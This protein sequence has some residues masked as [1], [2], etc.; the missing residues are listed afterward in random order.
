[1]SL[2][3]PI[4]STI[5][6]GSG[7][8]RSNSQIAFFDFGTTDLSTEVFSDQAL[9]V[10]ITNPVALTS[11]GNQPSIHLA[12]QFYVVQLQD[13]GGTALQQI[14]KYQ[15]F[16]TDEGRDSHDWSATVTYKFN[17]LVEN[18]EKYY[19]SIKNGNIGNTP[20][21][22]EDDPNW[23]FANFHSN[24]NSTIDYPINALV[25]KNGIFYRGRITP[26]ISNDPAVTPSA[27]ANMSGIGP[28]SIDLFASSW[29]LPT[30]DPAVPG[31]F[32]AGDI[33]YAGL[34]FAKDVDLSA[35]TS[36]RSPVSWDGGI[37]KISLT[38]ARELV[39]TIANEDAIFN[40]VAFTLNDGVGMAQTYPA[41]S[42]FTITS[43]TAK[44]L[45]QSDFV[46]ISVSGNKLPGS[47]VHLRITRKGTDAADTIDDNIFVE[48]MQ[49][50]YVTTASTDSDGT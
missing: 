49:V 36:F 24:F 8:P 39:T 25:T 20:T 30:S 44:E 17:D 50:I 47:D 10:R 35:Q 33:L 37:L 34:N 46:T 45:K 2:F 3:I 27:W 1:M 15:G 42:D 43:V 4:F 29:N 6:D 13:S 26:N 23:R 7:D 21:T 41:G 40:V 14:D 19:F 28:Q 11:V 32:Q 48:L 31:S 5:T 12:D 18:E 9:T 16:G 22:A 38:W